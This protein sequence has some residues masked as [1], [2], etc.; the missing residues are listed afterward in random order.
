MAITGNTFNLINVR[1]E[2]GPNTRPSTQ[3]LNQFHQAIFSNS[4]GWST[5]LTNTLLRSD[6]GQLRDFKNTGK[7]SVSYTSTSFQ[8]DV[9]T[10]KYNAI[11]TLN[12]NPNNVAEVL[13]NAGNTNNFT[14]SALNA[15]VY[16][17]YHKDNGQ[18]PFFG[19]SLNQSNFF[20]YSSS[21][22]SAQLTINGLDI[23]SLYQVRLYHYNGYNFDSSDPSIITIVNG[24]TTPAAL[25]LVTPGI[26][27]ATHNFVTITINWSDT[28]AYSGMNYVMKYKIDGQST[29]YDPFSVSGQ[30]NWDG[31][32]AKSA[33]WGISVIPNTSVDVV[34]L[35]AVRAPY[36]DS[37]FG[38]FILPI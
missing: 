19:Q 4:T 25:Q 16:A 23:S 9:S 5:Y 3:G 35:K 34:F 37:Q 33:V 8:W 27:S 7:P 22:T 15:T 17:E 36:I 10:E 24:I 14:L 32:G 2:F 28:N 18:V 11:L 26:T 31:T 38:E 21:N 6:T 12:V 20:I 1:D 29:E 30:T 13:N